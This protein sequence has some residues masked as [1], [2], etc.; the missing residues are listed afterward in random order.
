[1]MP[2]PGPRVHA[3][4][5]GYRVGGRT[6]FDVGVPWVSL[7]FV[8]VFAL[9]AV[10]D[11]RAGAPRAAHGPVLPRG[12]RGRRAPRP[13]RGG[14]PGRDG[15][16][17]HRRAPPRSG[18]VDGAGDR[19]GH[20]GRLAGPGRGGVPIGRPGGRRARRCRR[21]SDRGGGDR[22]ATGLA[23]LVAARARR[24]VPVPPHPPHP[25]RRLRRRR[26]VPPQ[27]RRGGAPGRPADRRPRAG[28]RPRGRLDH[29]RQAGAGDTDDARAGRAGVGVRGRQ[30]PAQPQGDVARPRRRLQAGA[31]LGPCPCGRLRGRPLLPRRVGGLGRRPP[32][33]PGRP[34]PERGR[35]AAGVRGRRHL[36]GRLHAV[37]RGPRRDGRP[38]VEW[39]PRS[40]SGRPALRVGS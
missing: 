10:I 35:V 16:L 5:P 9:L 11:R 27:A 15:G 21:R 24:P 2:H 20:D 22:A 23:L 4:S 14:G 40:R 8:L 39:H 34:D 19:P 30:L 28:L 25:Q 32:V 17:R 6:V 36:G 18:V 37:L 38:R 13:H 12:V 3:G 7:A 26:P 1:M 33:R 29:R 31:G